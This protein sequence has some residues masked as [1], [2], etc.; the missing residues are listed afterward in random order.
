MSDQ[1]QQ[2]PASESTEDREDVRDFVEDVESDPS[3]NPDADETGAD[4]IRGG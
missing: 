3:Q 4:R 1:E 2:S